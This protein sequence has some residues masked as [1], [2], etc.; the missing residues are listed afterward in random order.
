MEGK[1]VILSLKNTGLFYKRKTGLLRH[2]KYWALRDVSF[3]LYHGETLGIIGKNGV[4]KSTVLRM[5]AG[6]IDPDRGEVIRHEP[7]RASLL[8]LQVGFIAHLTGRQ[9]AI[10]GGLVLGLCRAEVEALLP[11]IIEFSE[12]G[13]FIDQPVRSYSMGMRARLGFSVAL[14]ADPDILLV[15]EVLGVGDEDFQKKSADAIR[16][17]SRRA[18]KV[19]PG[20][21][22]SHCR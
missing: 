4:G 19:P 11:Q 6:V 7:L 1:K 21:C 18:S 22:S 17:I 3:D 9:N 8:A 20:A 15:D 10:L 13:D 12:L 16:E 5:I 2:D 14:Y